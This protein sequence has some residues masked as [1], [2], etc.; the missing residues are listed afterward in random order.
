MLYSDYFSFVTHLFSFIIIISSRLGY[1]VKSFSFNDIKCHRDFIKLVQ[2]L[3]SD[4]L[5]NSFHHISFFS[6]R[7]RRLKRK[8]QTT[9]KQIHG[10]L[11]LSCE[12]FLWQLYIGIYHICSYG[13]LYT[14]IW[15]LYASEY[16]WYFLINIF[17]VLHT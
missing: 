14:T 10:I 8:S 2:N 4:I 9:A 16:L 6:L 3:T 11:L 17:S 12:Y 1:G 13:S 15:N 5:K 7:A